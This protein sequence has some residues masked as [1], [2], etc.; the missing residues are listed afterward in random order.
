MKKINIWPGSGLPLISIVTLAL[1]T[2][3][4]PGRDNDPQ[5]RPASSES[6]R[7]QSAHEVTLA[8]AEAVPVEVM[9]QRKAR[10]AGYHVQGM[11]MDMA[12]EAHILP[13]PVVGMPEVNREELQRQQPG[14]V[15]A[16]RQQPVSTFAVDV[17]TGS[18]SLLRS[19][20]QQGRLLPPGTV[21][22]EEMVNYFEYEVQ[23]D[24]ISDEKFTLATELAPSPYNSGKQLLKVQLA[25]QS[26]PM[27]ELPGA[28][29]VF[30]V[31]VSG[32]MQDANKLPLLQQ[33]MRM[34]AKQLNSDDRVSLVTYAG[35]SRVV[36]E[37][38]AGDSPSLDAGIAALTAGGST[39]GS[40]GIRDAYRLA[41]AHFIAD[42]IN[43]VILAT[44][45]DFNVGVT[46]KGALLDII[47][48]GK[49]SDVFLS[50]LGFGRGNLQEHTLEQLA[51]KGNGHYAYI[52]NFSEGR[53]VLVNQLSSSLAVIAREVKLQ[54]EF[55]PALVA[56]YRLIGYENRQ[57][58]RADFNND[59]VDGGEVGAGHQVTA[60]YELALVNGQRDMDPL[61]YGGQGDDSGPDH[62]ELAFVKLRYQPPQGGQ[63]KLLT[64]AV[65]WGTAY[66]SL[67]Q[68]SQD[69]RFAAA[70]AGLGQLLNGGTY[71]G[72]AD[73]GDMIALANSAVGQD[74]WGY[75]REFINLAL[76]A[77]ALAQIEAPALSQHSV[78]P[79]PGAYP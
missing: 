60:L 62:D 32:S 2:A 35:S 47:S 15:V 34:L 4:S 25:T 74:T 36:F 55:N 67:S 75:R 76:S 17:D 40:A 43:R 72:N 68:T 78:T 44:D 18:Y 8:E 70:V 6:N 22:T 53:K 7:D 69:M 65:S 19:Y 49:Q 45:G 9:A 27:E 26:M 12:M 24:R 14:T 77:Q 79:E 54:L 63:S 5:T 56:E 64:K 30:L 59:K 39:H 41:K 50:V 71:I 51:D 1:L 33:S 46:D 23:G 11:S 10:I 73:Y 31:D 38:I 16:T 20:L 29:L 28:N 52:D 42:G 48:Q 66:E 57:L 21:R 37:G 58:N 3:C 61:R 13:P